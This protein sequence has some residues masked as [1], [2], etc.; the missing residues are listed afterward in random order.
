MPL[1]FLFDFTENL[2]GDIG[3]DVGSFCA[4]FS[5]LAFF[6][7]YGFQDHHIRH[8]MY[9]NSDIIRLLG[10]YNSTDTSCAWFIP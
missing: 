8:W 1:G 3:V 5:F 2:S 6:L 9:Y 4:G 7:L 10:L